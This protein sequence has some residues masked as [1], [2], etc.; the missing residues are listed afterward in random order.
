[1][2]HVTQRYVEQSLDDVRLRRAVADA[3]L[4]EPCLA[5]WGTRTLDRPLFI[6]EAEM[7]ACAADVNAVFDLL[8]TLPDRVFDGDVRRYCAYLGID[9]AI[10]RLLHEY[11]EG[12][13]TRYGRADLSYDGASFTLLE[14]NVAS[15]IGGLDI[16]ELHRALLEVEAF[17]GFAEEHRLRYVDPAELVVRSLRAAAPVPDP[18]VAMVCADDDLAEYR[19]MLASFAVALGR[20]GLPVVIGGL[21][22]IRAVGRRLHLGSTRVDAVLRYFT[23][24]HV[25][26]TAHLVEPILRA[27]ENGTATLFTTMDSSL[28]SNKAALSLLSEPRW[29]SPPERALIDRVLPRTRILTPALVD[30]CVGD[31]DRLILKPPRDFGGR[32]VVA[33]WETSAQEWK[34]L[35]NE[36]ADESYVVQKRV[37]PA[38]EPVVDDNGTIAEWL[39]AWGVFVTPEGYGG[40][41][42]RALPSGTG[43]VVNLGAQTAARMAGPFTF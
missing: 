28:Y 15:D 43:A 12:P 13:P 14:F 23:V 17:A 39:T 16:A 35:L 8:A 40:A 9:P 5:N 20:F 7:R 31:R 3:R 24:D 37:V 42:V 26:H 2:N 36:H 19:P 10:A 6:P 27:H 41:F 21:S 38:T 18:V 22:D 33:G 11:R 1:M 32:G 25:P 29:W 30:H 34:E 4:S